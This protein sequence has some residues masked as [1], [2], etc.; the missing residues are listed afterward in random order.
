MVTHIF[1]KR[2]FVVEV[3]HLINGI[4]DYLF[5]FCRNIRKNVKDCISLV[6]STSTLCNV[7]EHFHKILGYNSDEEVA[8]FHERKQVVIRQRQVWEIRRVKQ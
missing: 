5:Y 6:F 4:C 2:F 1:T 8:A 7:A 3:D